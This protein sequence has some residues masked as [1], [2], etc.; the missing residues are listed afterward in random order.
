MFTTPR[1]RDSNKRLSPVPDNATPPKDSSHPGGLFLSTRQKLVDENE[2]FPVQQQPNPSFFTPVA[3][4]IYG[5]EG[6]DL[7]RAPSKPQKTLE[8]FVP[9]MACCRKLNFDD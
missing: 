6:Q 1:R 4:R 2:P 3:Q 8:R 5:N 7:L 9:N